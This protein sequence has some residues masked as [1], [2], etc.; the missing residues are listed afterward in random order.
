VERIE[1]PQNRRSRRTRAA[2]LDAAWALLEE[3]GPRHTT[4]A[5]VAERAG[6]SRRAL[7]L[8]VASRAE[9]LLA[10]HEHVDETLDLDACLDPVRDAPDAAGALDAFA[11]HL[12]SYHVRIL[13]VDLALL[14]AKDD[15]PDVAVLVDRAVQRWHG[16]CRGITGRLADEGRLAEPWTADTAADLLWS[17]MFPDTLERLTVGRGWSSDRYRELLTVLLRRTL[18]TP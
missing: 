17:F 18:V 5:A 3:R 6:V 9:L 1:E 8:H 13:P 16:A 10:L 7:Y 2:V 15:D 12:A 11:A 4:M 14:R